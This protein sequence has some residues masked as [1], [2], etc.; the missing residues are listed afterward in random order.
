VFSH[1]VAAVG[2]SDIG[3]D[4]CGSD[5]AEFQEGPLQSLVSFSPERGTGPT[6]QTFTFTDG[7]GEFAGATGLF[8]G[9]G[10]LVENGFT[11]SG[12]E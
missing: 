10:G 7:T 12:A 9:T 1:C 2:N 11:I 6:P 4:R 3:T 8:S 5:S